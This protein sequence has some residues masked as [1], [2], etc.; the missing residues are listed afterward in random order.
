DT[1]VPFPH[2][3]QP[4][5]LRP[6][7]TPAPQPPYPRLVPSPVHPFPG[8]TVE[9]QTRVRRSAHRSVQLVPW[10]RHMRAFLSEAH[11]PTSAPLSGPGTTSKPGILPVIPRPST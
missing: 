10:F 5:F 6:L 4:P 8:G 3:A 1:L 9:N 11:L 2:S 7:K